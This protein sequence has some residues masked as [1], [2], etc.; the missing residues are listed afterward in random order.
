MKQIGDKEQLERRAAALR[1]FNEW[2]TRHPI[3]MTPAEAL[4]AIGTLYELIPPESRQ[5]ALDPSGVQKMRQA[6]S[7]LKAST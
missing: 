1:R 3:E 4:A 7:H 5:R 6:L 2:E